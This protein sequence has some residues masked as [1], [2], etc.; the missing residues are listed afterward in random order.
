MI[1]AESSGG[2]PCIFSGIDQ[3]D[4]SFGPMARVDRCAIKTNEH[5]HVKWVIVGYSMFSNLLLYRDSCRVRGITICMC[6]SLETDWHKHQ[7]SVSSRNTFIVRLPAS[8]ETDLIKEFGD[9]CS[10][11]P[12]GDRVAITQ[13]QYWC[14]FPVIV[15]LLSIAQGRYWC[16]FPGDFGSLSIA[17]E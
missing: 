12:L 11:L 14:S 15:G 4:E 16:S 3:D 7:C 6:A 1:C 9:S 2:Y 10:M 8:W 17:Q 13:E 5:V